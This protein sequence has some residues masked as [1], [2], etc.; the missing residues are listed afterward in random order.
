MA[1]LTR[2]PTGQAG[3]VPGIPSLAPAP[4][5]VD[6]RDRQ[7]SRRAVATAGAGASVAHP[8]LRS[9]GR[10]AATIRSQSRPYWFTSCLACVNPLTSDKSIQSISPAAGHSL[11][12]TQLQLPLP[13]LFLFLPSCCIPFILQL[14]HLRTHSTASPSWS[15]ISLPD[16]CN[17]RNY[18]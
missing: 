10:V 12:S 14:T 2:I 7:S 4:I 17:R 1:C 18:R 8:L 16:H 5:G 15:L 6:G 9:R 13:P 3:A 11:P